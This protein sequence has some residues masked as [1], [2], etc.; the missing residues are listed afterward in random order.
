MSTAIT[1]IFSNTIA[2]YLRLDFLEAKHIGVNPIGN[3]MRSTQHESFLDTRV[4]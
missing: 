4:N 3:E 2:K 1:P